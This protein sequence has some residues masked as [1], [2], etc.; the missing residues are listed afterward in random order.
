MKGWH[1]GQEHL[2]GMIG[3]TPPASAKPKGGK[4]KL[5]ADNDAAEV[6]GAA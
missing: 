1:S 6:S 3:E 2:L 4:P 5:V